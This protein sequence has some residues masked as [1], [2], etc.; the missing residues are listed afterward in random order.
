MEIGGS[1]MH[2]RTG[3]IKEK[4]RKRENEGRNMLEGTGYGD[5]DE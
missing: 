2:E 4:D 3:Y 1:D 5:E